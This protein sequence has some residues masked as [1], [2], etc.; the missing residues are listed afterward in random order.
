M[1]PIICSLAGPVCDSLGTRAPLARCQRS[2]GGRLGSPLS[3]VTVT[4]SECVRPHATQTMSPFHTCRHYHSFKPVPS[5]GD[6]HGLCVRKVW[7]AQQLPLPRWQVFAC[8]VC[9]R[10]HRGYGKDFFQ[11]PSAAC[12]CSC[13]SRQVWSQRQLY[14]FL[15][16]AMRL[17]RCSY[18][19]LGPIQTTINLPAGKYTPPARCSGQGCRSKTFEPCR[20]SARCVDWRKARLQ[21]LVGADK[22]VCACVCVCCVCVCASFY[23]F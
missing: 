19:R 9:M 21:E 17:G 13:A 15:L 10:V 23:A 16:L 11:T 7:N 1:R 18:S 12:A 14:R 5:P 6:C 4:S 3:N 2:A 22:Q 8:P 20:D